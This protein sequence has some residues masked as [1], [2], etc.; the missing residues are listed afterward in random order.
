MTTERPLG[1][2]LH[3][4]RDDIGPGHLD[5]TLARLAD[6]GF[7]HAE[8]FDILSDP[9]GLAAGPRRGGLRA[10]TAHAAVARRGRRA[11]LDAAGV[12]GLDTVTALAIEESVAALGAAVAIG[13]TA[14]PV[15][16]MPR[17]WDPTTRTFDA[18]EQK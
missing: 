16:P 14:P 8:P 6:M 11:V 17:Q 15:V 7:T 5:G 12:L 4:V 13:T 2:Q 9:A 18:T 10:T 3:S 1:V